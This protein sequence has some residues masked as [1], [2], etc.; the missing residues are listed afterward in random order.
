M[1]RGGRRPEFGPQQQSV[2]ARRRRAGSTRGSWARQWAALA[3]LAALLF[4]YRPG[5]AQEDPFAAVKAAIRANQLEPAR[6][7]L[8]SFLAQYPDSLEG[9]FLLAEVETRSGNYDA[10]IRLYRQ[11]LAEQPNLAR[12]QLELGRALFQ[13]KQDRE[14]RRTFQSALKQELPPQVRTNVQ[15]FL[16]ALE[17]RKQYFFN[18]SVAGIYDTDVNQAPQLNEITLFGLPFQLSKSAQSRADPGLVISGNG[19][20]WTPIA[21]QSRWR[22]GTSFYRNEYP[23][24]FF[25]DM[26][27]RFYT[28]PQYTAQSWQVAALGVYAKRTYGND[29]YNS[30]YGPRLEAAYRLSDRILI[31][32]AA[33]YLTVDY[34]SLSFLNGFD[35]A[36]N[37]FT[38]YLINPDIFVRL[39]T[40]VARERTQN[41]GFSYHALR[42]GLGYHQE[43]KNGIAVDLQPE[44][45]VTSYDAENPIFLARRRDQ[46]VSA[47]AILTDSRLEFGGALPYLSYTYTNDM[48]NLQ[49]YSY[50]RHQIQLGLTFHF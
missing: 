42:L 13:A 5:F 39:I 16:S 38:T 11:M 9:R 31:E 18:L 1:A 43:F 35:A 47:R 8:T 7:A 32:N 30:G 15:Q 48:S 50:R 40:G 19:E 10:A 37:L 4:I 17:A 34:H 45:F 12:V 28:G 24:G 22:F 49:F 29:P 44:V 3:L 21:T 33:E 14:A 6:E 23:T 46:I 26:Q 27:V 25:D 20:Y 36:D 41:R 2:W